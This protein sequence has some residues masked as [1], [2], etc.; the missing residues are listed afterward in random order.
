MSIY[1]DLLERGYTDAQ[2]REAAKEYGSTQAFTVTLVDSTDGP[3]VGLAYQCDFRYEEEA[4]V[5]DIRKALHKEGIKSWEASKDAATHA[6]AFAD[7]NALAVATRPIGNSAPM[8]GDSIINAQRDDRFPMLRGSKLE[9]RDV[10]DSYDKT[11]ERH[12]EYVQHPPRIYPSDTIATIRALADKLG[13]EGKRPRKK[14]ELIDM[15]KNSE[16]YK[17]A[18]E[19]P[20]QWPGY[21]H[22][23]DVLVLRADSGIAFDVLDLLKTAAIEGELMVG[24][25]VGFGS[26]LSLFDVADLGRNVRKEILENNKWHQRE[27]KKLEPVKKALKAE[28]IRWFYLGNPS[29]SDNDPATKYWLNG[30]R[31]KMND[32]S[33]AQPFGWYT[34][35]EL[36]AKKFL[37]PRKKD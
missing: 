32:G 16:E 28:G 21:F 9:G 24:S 19:H 25:T 31:Q 30:D 34:R 36:L 11:W 10:Y 2:I 17:A 8:W 6:V 4:G 14:A 27:M 22:Y 23:G 1:T 33:E 29:K 20:N 3:L 12:M 18:V 26:G 13:I 15:V 7:V 5:G 37:E 35:E